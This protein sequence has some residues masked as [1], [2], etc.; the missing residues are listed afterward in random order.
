M[1]AELSDRGVVLLHDI[2]NRQRDL[3]VWRLWEDIR[4]SDPHQELMHGHGLGVLAVG[5]EQP[6]EFFELLTLDT[7]HASVLRELFRLLGYRLRLEHQLERA[8]AREEDWQETLRERRR[9]L[10]KA[11]QR[12][13]RLQTELGKTA[14]ELAGAQAGLESPVA[15]PPV[16]VVARRSRPAAAREYRR[17]SRVLGE[18]LVDEA[19]RVLEIEANAIHGVARRLDARALANV[20]D[21]C[22]ACTG[23]LVVRHREVGNRRAQ[24]RKHAHEHWNGCDLRGSRGRA[25]WGHRGGHS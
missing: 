18:P 10:K 6:P 3:G 8:R 21:I 11:R 1:D 2:N 13:E 4:D 9:E 7:E 17:V 5:P 24:D 14:E 25:P 23:K 22:L 20:V 15:R 12:L 19:V 16:D